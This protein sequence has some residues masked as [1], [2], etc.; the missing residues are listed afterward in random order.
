MSGL[1]GLSRPLKK[2]CLL[3]VVNFLCKVLKEFFNIIA[4]LIRNFKVLH[5]VLLSKLFCFEAVD[6]SNVLQV[7]L[8]TAEILYSLL[9]C[10]LLNIF[11]PKGTLIKRLGISNI[12]ANND[13]VGVSVVHPGDL[14][15]AFLPG[16]VPN[17]ESN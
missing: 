2:I 11:I 14:S 8:Q 15:K 4:S 10:V 3:V 6:L 12:V 9:R 16:S 17:E 5:F 7:G 1:V 13:A